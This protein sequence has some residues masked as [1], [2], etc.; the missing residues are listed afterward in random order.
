MYQAKDVASSYFSAGRVTILPIFLCPF[1]LSVA[2]RKISDVFNLFRRR[3]KEAKRP[4]PD[5]D[6][7]L[8][9]FGSDMWTLREAYEGVHIFGGVG[10][11]KSTGSGAALAKTFLS[12]GFG[13]LVCCAKPEDR[14]LWER[15]AREV[16]RSGSLVI[17]EP[18]QD[19][20]PAPW[21]FNFL[22]YGLSR[23]AQGGSQTQSI[24]DLLV[25]VLEI[26]EGVAVR[27]SD[28]GKRLALEELLRNA[29][30]LL[31]LAE[32]PLT[33]DTIS[34]LVL[35]APGTPVSLLGD[36]PDGPEA[37]RSAGR[38]RERSYTMRCI[39]RAQERAATARE[40]NDFERATAYWLTAFPGLPA[41]LRGD[42]VSTFRSQADILL[43]GAAWELLA[44]D[45]NIVPEVTYKHGAVIILD[46][47]LQ[48]HRETGRVV[49]GIWKYMFQQALL[50]RRIEED[51]L[52]VFLWCDEAQHFVTA[53]DHGFQ[54]AARSIGVSTVY[55]AHSLSAYHSR[56]GHQARA[57]TD[58]LLALFQ[59]K[60]FHAN[61]DPLT[62]QYAADLI[63]QQWTTIDS[64][65][66]QSTGS[67]S[68][69]QSESVQHKLLPSAFTR[70]RKGGPGT[71]G[72]VDAIIFQ[73]GRTWTQTR[74][75]FLP[76]TFTQ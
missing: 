32:E 21:R 54:S 70:L 61:T 31:A 74:D 44:T 69:G 36:A 16:G 50:R 40:H 10:S 22:E 46:L 48:E 41:Y 7:P 52:P 8:L 64:W 20:R 5:L 71:Q 35:D 19:P 57:Q 43:Q 28:G 56:L 23:P 58:A 26:V 11:G 76:V 67:S 63:G 42:I 68:F 29:V 38:W 4:A 15:C 60:I 24:V 18:G 62:N 14:R 51:P 2:K 33:L 30:T 13:G 59:T 39:V 49:Q 75:T 1:A 47:S 66:S 17:V 37:Q 53:Y 45:T 12:A 73:V 34:R 27:A 9:H 25:S 3:P 65:S 6:A 55:V 72:L